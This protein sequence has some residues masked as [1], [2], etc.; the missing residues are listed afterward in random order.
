MKLQ[1]NRILAVQALNCTAYAD[2]PTEPRW[3]IGQQVWLDRKNLPL[4][5]GTIKLAPWHY[6]PFKITKVIS[7]VAYHLKL[8]IQ[9]NIHPVFHASLL[10]PYV[11]TK[12]HGPNFSHPPP[13]L[14]IGE[15]KYEVETIWKHRQFRWNKR[16]QYLLKWKGYPESNNTWEPTE[17]LHA[18]QLLKEYHSHHPLA[19]IKTLLIQHQTHSLPL[20]SFPIQN[21]SFILTPTLTS[22]SS[23]LSQT[24]PACPCLT[25]QSTHPMNPPLAHLLICPCYPFHSIHQ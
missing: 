11:K 10:T 21:W 9:W 16:L 4:S 19:H 20:P 24:P 6:G 7:P 22:M 18:P 12:T 3:T 17:Q 8:P 23:L 2:A 1:D 15:N 13:D 25:S 5:Y 14:T